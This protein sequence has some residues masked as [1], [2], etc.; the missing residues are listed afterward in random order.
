MDTKLK[1]SISDR[2]TSRLDSKWECMSETCWKQQK[3]KEDTSDVQV[4]WVASAWGISHVG[5]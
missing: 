5:T 3:T 4:C 2:S 1:D